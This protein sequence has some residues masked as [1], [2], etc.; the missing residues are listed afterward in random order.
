MIRKLRAI[1]IHSRIWRTN[2][3]RIGH[4][5]NRRGIL[6]HCW[7]SIYLWCAMRPNGQPGEIESKHLHIHYKPPALATRYFRCKPLQL[8]V[9][10]FCHSLAMIFLNGYICLEFLT[11]SLSLG[12]NFACQ[13][14]RVSHDPHEIRVSWRSNWELRS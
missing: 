11:A 3:R 4:W 9:P 6:S 10:L 1:R 5:S 7:P 12:Y 8:R 14:C 13:E 2:G